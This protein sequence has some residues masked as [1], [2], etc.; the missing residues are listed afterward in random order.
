MENDERDKIIGRIRKLLALSG[1][2]GATEAEAIAA[3]MMA[4]RL[5]ADNDVEDW[6][7]HAADEQPIE[8][9]KSMPVERRWRW[10]LA[11]AVGSNFRCRYYQNRGRSEET[12]WERI[13]RMVFYGYR[14]DA[15]A[16]ALAFD[17]LYRTGD[18]L[19]K[20]AANAAYREY[21]SS[22]GVYNGFVLGFVA[23]V[24]SEL[25]KQSQALMIVV[26]P[27]VSES[28]AELSEGFG[29]ADCEVRM[30]YT[31]VSCDAYRDGYGNG[32]EA[33][34]SRRMDAPDEQGEQTIAALPA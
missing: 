9:I 12:R 25:E 23:G 10:E 19:A 1:D 7:L 2:K 18:R 32:R 17:Y 6:E 31:P 22:E 13:T 26:P 24:R 4:Q 33:I 20:R 27:K 15:E 16:A 21:G 30:I 34:R 5:M 28:Y 3:V 29:E 11:D 8:K 14:S